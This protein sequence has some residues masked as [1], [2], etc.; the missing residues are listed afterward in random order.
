[1]AQLSVLAKKVDYLLKVRRV[2]D[3]KSPAPA[4]QPLVDARAGAGNGAAQL[5]T[6]GRVLVVDDEPGL[7]E[8]VCKWLGAFG[9]VA[10][11]ADSA[12]TALRR[13]EA[14]Q[15]DILFTDVVMPGSMNGIDL[16]RVAEKMQPNIRIC[17]TSGNYPPESV[18]VLTAPSS[19]LT[20]PYRKNDLLKALTQLAAQ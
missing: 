11:S 7:C 1:L 19:M 12:D 8:L 4:L 5:A 9:Y 14:E 2:R 10:V 18:T 20:K 3:S 16:A 6:G 15:F 17:V 13:L